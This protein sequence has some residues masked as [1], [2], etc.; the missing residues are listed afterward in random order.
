MI[1][2]DLNV[3]K[4]QKAIMNGGVLQQQQT[5]SFEWEDAKQLE[6]KKKLTVEK[7]VHLKKTLDA[8]LTKYGT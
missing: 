8:E 6:G 7:R 2:V 3:N 1:V 5:I 4:F